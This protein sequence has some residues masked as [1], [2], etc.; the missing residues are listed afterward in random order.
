M[1]FFH[2]PFS[3]FHFL[4]AFV[5]RWTLNVGRSM[6]VFL[7]L[8]A[9]G[10]LVVQTN[11]QTVFPEGLTI[12]STTA[13]TAPNIAFT[14]ATSHAIETYI[15]DASTTNNLFAATNT[16]TFA[17]IG[18]P[19]PTPRKVILAKPIDHQIIPPL[20]IGIFPAR[21]SEHGAILYIIGGPLQ[22]SFPNAAPITDSPNDSTP[23]N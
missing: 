18:Q 3:I 1:N 12:I 11:A 4:T 20:S 19:L 9:L 8:G 21:T 6:F 14:N 16:V 7:I 23:N 13:I 10:D 15:F 5:G 2:F 22:T 17:K